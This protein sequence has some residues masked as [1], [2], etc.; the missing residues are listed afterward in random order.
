MGI[1][2][3]VSSRK[4][5]QAMPR[6][7]GE[8]MG[9]APASQGLGCGGADGLWYRGGVTASLAPDTYYILHQYLLSGR[10]MVVLLILLIETES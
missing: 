5:L 2:R 3:R 4:D 7:C 1:N 8:E 10:Y 9:K 6:G